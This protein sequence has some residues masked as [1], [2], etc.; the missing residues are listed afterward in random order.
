MDCSQGPWTED[1]ALADLQV[2]ESVHSQFLH[3]WMT[4]NIWRR[5]CIN[6]DLEILKNNKIKKKTEDFY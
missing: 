1:A 5:S 2:T 6:C 4:D 3:L